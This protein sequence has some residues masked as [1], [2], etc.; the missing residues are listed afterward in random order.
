MARLPHVANVSHRR[1]AARARDTVAIGCFF[2]VVIVVI[3]VKE[4]RTPG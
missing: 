4:V 3:T 2:L 1:R